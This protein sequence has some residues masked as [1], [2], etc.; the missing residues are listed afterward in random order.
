MNGRTVSV[1]PDYGDQQI[2]VLGS[3]PEP[4]DGLINIAT[5]GQVSMVS[6]VFEPGEYR[7]PA[8]L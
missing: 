1:Y 2:A 6:D 8:L 7:D 5:A 3:M 4:G